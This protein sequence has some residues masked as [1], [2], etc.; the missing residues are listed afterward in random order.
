M[1]IT[2]ASPET[3]ASERAGSYGHRKDELRKRLSRIEGQVRGI[4]RMV[5]EEKY[6]VDI[7]VQIAAVRAALDRVALGVLED[8]VKGCVAGAAPGHSEAMAEELLEV[9]E[10]FIAL[11]R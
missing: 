7:L 9:V 3:V 11:R 6:C 8:H 2:E 1:G 10:R 4:D 5:D